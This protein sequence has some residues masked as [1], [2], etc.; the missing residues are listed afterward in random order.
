VKDL[1]LFKVLTIALLVINA[2]LLLSIATSTSDVYQQITDVHEHVESMPIADYPNEQGDPNF[3]DIRTLETH[4]C[5][6]SGEYQLEVEMDGILVYDAGRYVGF[7]PFA[8]DKLDK[9]IM[10]DNR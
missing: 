4:H 7:K 2:V 6:V 1:S 8:N 9:L 10:K 3:V 5:E